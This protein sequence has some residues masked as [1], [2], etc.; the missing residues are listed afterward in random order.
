MPPPLAIPP[1]LSRQRQATL[2]DPSKPGQTSSKWRLPRS[3]FRTS[4]QPYPRSDRSLLGRQ[5]E[6]AIRK[7]AANLPRLLR[8]ER[9][10]P[11][12]RTLP[13]LGHFAPFFPFQLRR[14][15][16]RLNARQLRGQRQSMARTP[17]STL[18][19]PPRR[20]QAHAARSSTFRS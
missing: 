14:R 16:S 20:A 1:P 17:W 5:Y 18:E 7:R 8:P 6:G 4:A 12:T 11:Q 10:C 3:N 9:P 13:N 15:R 2:L 19:H